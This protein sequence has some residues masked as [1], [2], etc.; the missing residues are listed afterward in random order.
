MKPLIL[1]EVLELPWFVL[2]MYAKDHPESHLAYVLGHSLTAS[3]ITESTKD[4]RFWVASTTMHRGV[5]QHTHGLK[6]INQTEP[7]IHPPIWVALAR[8]GRRIGVFGASYSHAWKD[9]VPEQTAFY[10]PEKFAPDNW[11]MPARAVA[12]QRLL[13]LISQLTDQGRG[14]VSAR[15]L[16]S[17]AIIQ[18]LLLRLVGLHFGDIRSIALRWRL[19]FL[20]SSK[21]LIGAR[22]AFNEFLALYEL[23]KPDFSLFVTGAVATALHSGINLYLNARKHGKS[24]A[25]SKVSFAL[26]ELN[27]QV[28]MLLAVAAQRKAT[29]VLTSGYG[30][31]NIADDIYNNDKTHSNSNSIRRYW[32][33]HK[34]DKLIAWLGLD[35]SA[36]V[37]P[38]MMPCATLWFESD[39]D[40]D[41]AIKRLNQLRRI[42]DDAP[43]FYIEEGP[44]CISLKTMPDEAS[45]RSAMVRCR[46]PDGTQL[47]LPINRVGLVERKR[48]KLTGEHSPGGVLL[49]YRPE[50]TGAARLADIPAAAI[51]STLI[52]ALGARAPPNMHPPAWGLLQKF[53]DWSHKR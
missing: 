16:S 6:F 23:E 44:C 9:A 52:E 31:A 34:P 30:Q 18:F 27:D 35:K 14:K 32:V 1:F 47:S 24:Q 51:A 25:A 7:L 45:L 40:R 26:D 53:R 46:R 36:Q 38:S 41:Q 5:S 2:Q 29:L 48:R 3:V 17:V 28:G 43:L 15:L 10:V 13:R 21:N 22:L 12:Y 39:V 4:L 11:A 33:L 37:L 49:V 50:F 42:G 19:S 20:W 8:Q